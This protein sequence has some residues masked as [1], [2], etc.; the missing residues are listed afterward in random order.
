MARRARAY[1]SGGGVNRPGLAK[2][3]GAQPGA[4]RTNGK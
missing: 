2:A 3:Q 4:G 1:R